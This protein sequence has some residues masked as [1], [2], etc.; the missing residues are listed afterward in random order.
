M[1]LLLREERRPD[2]ILKEEKSRIL[3]LN[4]RQ[5]D[6]LCKSDVV[7]GRMTVNIRIDSS[8]NAQMRRLREHAEQ[9][10]GRPVSVAEAVYVCCNV[11]NLE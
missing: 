6:Q 10:L 2:M 8:V 7:I 1:I 11:A 4:D 3:A 5:L 9:R